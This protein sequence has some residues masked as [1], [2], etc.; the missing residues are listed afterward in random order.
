MT[1]PQ[2]F[3]IREAST[4]NLEYTLLAGE[5]VAKDI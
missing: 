5:G 4:K 3:V 1:T 2:G